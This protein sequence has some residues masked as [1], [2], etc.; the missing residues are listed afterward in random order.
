MSRKL[1]FS[2]SQILKYHYEARGCC[3]IITIIKQ[4]K[5]THLECVRKS[6]MC[7]GG[8][9][10]TP[11]HLPALLHLGTSRQT[12]R[13]SAHP[14]QHTTRQ[15]S[16][17]ADKT[18]P[19]GTG[20]DT[21]QHRDLIPWHTAEGYEPA[22]FHLS[23]CMPHLSARCTDVVQRPALSG[24]VKF[25]SWVSIEVLI[26]PKSNQCGAAMFLKHLGATSALLSSSSG[27][28]S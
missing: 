26:I 7:G 10:G 6:S 4:C 24:A 12:H 3:R 9:T 11:R 17:A 20:A 13:Q 25:S 23:E 2:E 16:A 14:N 27:G 18:S 19:A 1:W 5:R 21:D 8:E 15:I 22:L 28:Q